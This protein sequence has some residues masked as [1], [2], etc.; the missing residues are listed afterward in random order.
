M[1]ERVALDHLRHGGAP[2]P[3][4]AALALGVVP[5]ERQ[6]GL[7]A[8]EGR[9]ELD[10]PLRRGAR[11]LVAPQVAQHEGHQVVGVRVVGVERHGALQRRERFDVEAAAV[12]HLAQIEVDEARALVHL[13]HAVRR[14]VSKD[15]L[16]HVIASVIMTP[17]VPGC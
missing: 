5:L 9:V 6:I 16:R 11:I 13:V 12:V 10:G 3:R 17:A 8:G 15:G 14:Y 2:L 4:L 1:G 7:R